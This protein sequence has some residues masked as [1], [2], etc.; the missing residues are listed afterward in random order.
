MDEESRT[1]PEEPCP[2]CGGSGCII[3]TVPDCCGNFTPHGECRAHCAVPREVQEQCE[4]CGGSGSLS[5]GE[6]GR[7]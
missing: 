2:E 5:P 1:I 6:D 4:M 3:S 7:G